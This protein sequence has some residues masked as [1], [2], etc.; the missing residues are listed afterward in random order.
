MI[1]TNEPAAGAAGTPAG[2]APCVLVI[3][4]DSPLFGLLDTWLRAEGCVVLDERCAAAEPVDLVI[5]DVPFPRQAGVD[6][7]RQ[8][9]QRHPMAPILAV[10][11]T[12]IA[13]IEC[14]GPVARALGV[15]CVLPN[16]VSREALT[17]AVRRSLTTTAGR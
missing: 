16:P 8:I 5:V 10:S 3:N 13:G 7:I 6:W 12:F 15:A 11:S 2:R 17:Q 14:C 9:A 4:A 1:S